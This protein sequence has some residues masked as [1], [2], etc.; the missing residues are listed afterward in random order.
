VNRK[1]ETDVDFAAAAV[2]E[3][4]R[5]LKSTLV[6]VPPEK[7]T[8]INIEESMFIEAN[9]LTVCVEEKVILFGKSILN[10]FDTKS[11]SLYTYKAFVASKNERY[12]CPEKV[13]A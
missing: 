13:I 2:I 12:S 9:F 7:P 4:M 11:E 1:E 10:I 5:V 6:T 8:S 3:V